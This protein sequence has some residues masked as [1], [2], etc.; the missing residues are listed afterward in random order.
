MDNIDR[1]W[2]S[3]LM[4]SKGKHKFTTIDIDDAS[5]YDEINK[6]FEENKVSY[7]KV[8]TKNG[9][10]LL[11]E[12]NTIIPK[13]LKFNQHIGDIACPIPGTLQGGTEVKLI[14]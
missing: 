6:I 10:H 14:R 13:L 3:T 12:N 5:L 1:E 9:Y 4:A 2:S 8:V 11:F 7:H